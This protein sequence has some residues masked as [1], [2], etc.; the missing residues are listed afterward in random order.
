MQRHRCGLGGRV[1]RLGES[2]NKGVGLGL[3]GM[4]YIPRVLVHTMSLSQ[5][6][7]VSSMAKR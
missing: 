6:G 2:V 4:R 7:L 5:L 3:C 1:V